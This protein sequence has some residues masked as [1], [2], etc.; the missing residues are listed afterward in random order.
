M[1]STSVEEK[2]SSASTSIEE[3]SSHKSQSNYE[4]EETLLNKSDDDDH[5]SITTFSGNASPSWSENTNYS[6]ERSSYDI[7]RIENILN[8]NNSFR[9]PLQTST[10]IMRIGNIL[11]SNNSLRQSL[12]TSTEI[13]RIEN[14]LNITLPPLRHP[15]QSNTRNLPFI[16]PYCEAKGPEL[17]DFPY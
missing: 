9:Q 3:S 16:E 5:T 10:E 14:I 13:M 4:G 6:E 15:L 1:P 11:N 8:S 12:Q 2:T 17:P 7:M